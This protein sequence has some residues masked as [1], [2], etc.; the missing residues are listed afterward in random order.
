MFQLIFGA[1]TTKT[2]PY[3]KFPN[4]AESGLFYGVLGVL[5]RLQRDFDPIDLGCCLPI[6]D[7]PTTNLNLLVCMP[8]T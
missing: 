5:G 6:L 2:R 4:L 8:E 3:G 1:P 7:T